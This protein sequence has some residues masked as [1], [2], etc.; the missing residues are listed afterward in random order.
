MVSTS[1]PRAEVAAALTSALMVP[2]CEIAVADGALAVGHLRDV[3][4][5]ED[6]VDAGLLEVGDGLVALLL[7]AADQRQRLAAL[8]GQRLGDGKADALRAAGDDGACLRIAIG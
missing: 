8:V 4:A 7:R 3:G 6:R 1:E 2:K 5:D